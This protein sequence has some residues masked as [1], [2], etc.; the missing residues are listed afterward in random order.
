MTLRFESIKEANIDDLM[1][2]CGNMPGLDKN[3]IFLEGR[4]ARRKWL[5]EMAGKYKTIGMLAYGG[6]GKAKGF[7]ECLPASAHPLGI[8]SDD[9][10][11]TIIIDCAWYLQKRNMGDDEDEPAGTG[12]RKA[13]LDE[14]FSTGFFKK[15]L[16]KKC[17]YVDVL[18]LKNAP[19]MQY[20]FYHDYGFKDAIEFTGHHTIRYLLRYPVLGDDIKPRIEQVNFGTGSDKNVLTIGTY[21]QCHM[22]RMVNAKILKAVEGIEGLNVNIVDYWETGFPVMCEATINGMPAFDGHVYF[23]DDDAIRESIKAKIIP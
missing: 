2:I 4:K 18:T 16:G 23:M 15:Q 14:M 1:G 8:F 22:P 13:I 12:I 10:A 11:R 3:P 6:D 7:V 17:R 19:I 5:F 9:P 20:E 21:D